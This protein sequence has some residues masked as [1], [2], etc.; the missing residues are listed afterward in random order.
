MSLVTKCPAKVVT[1]FLTDELFNIYLILIRRPSV[2]P[3]RHGCRQADGHHTRADSPTGYR[4]ADGRAAV[5]RPEGGGSLSE[6]RGKTGCLGGGKRGVWAGEAGS[7]GG[8]VEVSASAADMS[9]ARCS[10]RQRAVL[11]SVA[12]G[13]NPVGSVAGRW[14]TATS[15]PRFMLQSYEK[16]A[17]PPSAVC[18]FSRLGRRWKGE[19]TKKEMIK[20]HRNHWFAQNSLYLCGNFPR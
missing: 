20:V 16:K 3:T 6:G 10:Y 17:R 8:G 12:G 14:L 13:E 11:I 4:A 18:S 1:Y 7:L 19:K 15:K 2:Q 5:G 9:S